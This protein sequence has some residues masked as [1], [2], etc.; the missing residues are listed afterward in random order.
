MQR[1]HAM[2]MTEFDRL[3]PREDGRLRLGVFIGILALLLQ[4]LL[5]VLH[6]PGLTLAPAQR[7][8][9]DVPVCSAHAAVPTKDQ[10]ARELPA[11]KPPPCPL[12][13]ALHFMGGYLPPIALLVPMPGCTAGAALANPPT[14]TA[15]LWTA[16]E[17]R[18]RAP[19][20]TA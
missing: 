17:G 4:T 15:P 13:Q 19:P 5:P 10:P 20:R 6:H 12:C 16:Y 8:V 9:L 18:P 11:H 2:L 14:G 3:A 1:A 7:L